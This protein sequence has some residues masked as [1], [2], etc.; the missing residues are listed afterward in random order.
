[1]NHLD[2]IFL[3]LA[4]FLIYRGYKRGFISSIR[5][6]LS[7][8]GGSIFSYLLSA[9]YYTM[10]YPS[11]THSKALAQF[12][13]F[14]LFFILFY[15]LAYYAEKGLLKLM[16]KVKIEWL[17]EAL[18]GFLGF[19]KLLVVV[20][21]FVSAVGAYNI[22]FLKKP[23]N[24]SSLVKNLY[25]MV[26][27]ASGYDLMAKLKDGK[28][29]DKVKEHWNKIRTTY[30]E[31]RKKLPEKEQMKKYYKYYKDSEGVLRPPKR[32]EG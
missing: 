29:N 1:M 24:K 11:V 27:S 26:R 10:F 5:H 23:V 19:V 16:T 30:K 20:F 2:A 22:S 13:S 15:G 17:N 8:V 32:E 12:L 31:E 28:L 21:V 14:G 4:F 7:I 25:R 18:G 6:F 3:I 9:S